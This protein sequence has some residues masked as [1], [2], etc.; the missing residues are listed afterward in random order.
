MSSTAVSRGLVVDRLYS[1][2]QMLRAVADAVDR[3]M[4]QSNFG[5]VRLATKCG[6]AG[7]EDP[8]EASRAVATRTNVLQLRH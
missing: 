6:P 5:N 3:E 7:H 1:R 4:L 8:R 2:A